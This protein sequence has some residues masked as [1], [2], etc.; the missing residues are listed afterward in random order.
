MQ[1]NN[2]FTVPLPPDQAWPI[3]LDLEQVA[4]CLPGATI[5]SIDGDDFEG[6]AKIKV[7]P[8]TA[9]YKG[10]AR[11]VDKN[12]T[13][14]RA[15][16]RASGKDAR[17]QGNVAADISLQLVA[18]G[19]GSKVLVE[20]SM[21]ISGKIAQFGRGVINDAAG[22]ILGIFAERL[23]ELMIEDTPPATQA[24][25]GDTTTSASPATTP[26]TTTPD[27][28]EALDLV[29]L[30]RT[31]RN[32]KTDATTTFNT[33]AAPAWIPTIIAALAALIS[34]F[35]AGYTAGTNRR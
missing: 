28:D 27:N 13:E 31:S 11:F 7:G 32:A 21:D 23:G 4:P 15:V 16:L 5:T 18:D 30:A 20:T 24:T 29:K 9:E 35:A 34:V 2:E 25:T 10:K 33:A 8:I 22:A 6:R 26:K 14:H 1:I 12:E 17:G 3:L 19:S